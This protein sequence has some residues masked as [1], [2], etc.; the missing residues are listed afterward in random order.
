MV[1]ESLPSAS[2]MDDEEDSDDYDIQDLAERSGCVQ[3]N[4]TPNNLAV[5]TAQ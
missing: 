4:G 3:V 5:V 1:E 2:A